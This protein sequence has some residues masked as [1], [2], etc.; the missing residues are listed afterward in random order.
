MPILQVTTETTGSV[1]VNPRIVHIVCND[2]LSVITA[3]GYLNGVSK[4]GYNFLPTDFV[5]VAY[6]TT[7]PT[8]PTIGIFRVSIVGSNIS[9]VA[10]I[11]EGNVSL[12]VTTNHIATFTN[13]TGVIG[14][15]AATAI[16]GG[17]LQAGL[18]G[19]AGTLASFPATAAKGSL[20]VIAVA[21][22][23]DTITAISNVA[24]GQASVI[25]IPDPVAATANFVVAPAALVSG[26][27]VKAS[28]TAGL[29][30]DA[31]FAVHAGTT[32]AYA[33]G[34]TSN[35]FVTTNMTAASQVVVT[36]K[37]CTN[38]VGYT[39]VAGTNTLTVTFSSDPGANTV[40][41]WHSITPAVA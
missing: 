21:N 37:S 13:T 39:A 3:T 2:I 29:L 16:N 26:N 10:D 8:T 7:S 34:G 14:D 5:V 27:V 25:S 6:G 1:S 33:G 9:L 24:M 19:T 23:G 32:A 20:K 22:T 18:S 15:D 35:V 36:L 12:P 38:I 41:T 11:S 31:G 40:F 28:G 17:N 30:V 4:Q